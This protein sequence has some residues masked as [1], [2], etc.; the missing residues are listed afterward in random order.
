MSRTPSGAGPTRQAPR[1][2]AKGPKTSP[3][4]LKQQSQRNTSVPAW[5][6]PISDSTYPVSL[7]HQGEDPSQ[8]SVR[9][10]AGTMAIMVLAAAFLFTSV[11][12]TG[13]VWVG[14]RFSGTTKPW[15]EFFEY[16]RAHSTALGIAGSH[17]GL[18][19]MIVVVWLYVRFI[20]RR[21]LS[22]IFSVSPGVRWRYAV[23]CLFVG[24]IV[25]G[26]V[27]SYY[28]MNG[29][30]WNPIPGYRTYLVVIAITVPLQALGEE[31]LFR[32]YLMQLCGSIV[33][34]EWFAIAMTALIFAIF[35]GSQNP[36]MFASRFIF[37]LIAGILVWKTGGLEAAVA[38]HVVNNLIVFA[39]SICNGTLVEVRGATDSPWTQAVSD[40]VMFGVCAALCWAIAVKMRVPIRVRAGASAK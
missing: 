10:M 20:H 13:V 14:Y 35:H 28:W 5:N 3:P 16:A 23:L 17:L 7:T 38:I 19:S 39:M 32:G 26:A 40:L 25:V 6:R 8:G 24:L 1:T 21:R 2:S 30:G 18:G 11:V 34:N 33:R 36:W 9:F 29:P 31:I 22:W 15:V 27:A 37:G 4:V 12:N